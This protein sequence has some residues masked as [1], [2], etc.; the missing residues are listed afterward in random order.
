M[1]MLM[2]CELNDPPHNFT[3]ET[4]EAKIELEAIPSKHIFAS[5]ARSFF[6]QNTPHFIINVLFYVAAS[7]TNI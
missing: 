2:G 1:K 5:T 7:E 4:I 6:T 3:F